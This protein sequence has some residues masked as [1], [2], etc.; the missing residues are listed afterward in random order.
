MKTRVF[1]GHRILDGSDTIVSED[2]ARETIN[3]SNEI[4]E[5]LMSVFMQYGPEVSV[6]SLA[7][8]Y[9]NMLA[10]FPEEYRNLLRDHVRNLLP[11]LESAFRMADLRDVPLN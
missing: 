5:L 11:A 1:D 8:I 2:F 4:R 10:V 7:T 3:C 9:I 6:N